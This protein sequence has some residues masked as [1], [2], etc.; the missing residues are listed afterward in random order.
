VEGTA[1]GTTVTAALIELRGKD[2]D[3]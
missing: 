3:R 1:R 2:S